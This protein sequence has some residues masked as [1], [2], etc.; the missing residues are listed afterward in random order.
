[1]FSFRKWFIEKGLC[2]LVKTPRRKP[3]N[4]KVRLESLEERVNPSPIVS[5]DLLD[6]APGSTALITANNFKVGSEVVFQV[7][8]M[9]NAGPDGVWG[10]PDDVL[11]TVKN[12]GPDHQ[13]WAVT[14]GV[15]WMV[16]AGADNVA[17]TADD[18]IA[19]DLDKCE[20][21]SIL[22]SWFVNP[23]DSI[24]AT[25]GLSATGLNPDGVVETAMAIFTDAIKTDL[26][27][28]EN[29]VSSGVS[30]ANGGIN[31]GQGLYLEGDYIPH[32]VSFSGLTVG[33][34]YMFNISFN[35]FQASSNSG[36]FV[37]IGTY[38]QSVI[39]TLVFPVGSGTPVNDP[40]SMPDS[41]GTFYISNGGSVSGID[42]D[43]TNVTKSLAISTTE[44]QATVTFKALDTSA[45]FYY[46]LKLA[47]P[48]EVIVPAGV[49]PNTNPTNGADG[50]TGLSLQSSVVNGP[51]GPAIGGGGN[52]QVAPGAVVQGSI[53]GVKWSDLNGNGIKESNEP[54][55]AGWTIQIYKDTDGDKIFGAGDTLIASTI[56]ADGSSDANKDGKIDA[57]D[58]GYY[59]FAVIRGTYFVRE[60]QQLGWTPTFPINN[61][62]GLL[63]IDETTPLYAN[64]NFG[65]MRDKPT[66]DI[67]KE[68]TGIVNEGAINQVLVYTFTVTNTSPVTTGSETINSL[69][70]TILGDL[71]PAFKAA[72]GGSAIIAA[73]ATVTFTVNYTAPAA[74]AGVSIAN[75][76][77]VVG[78][79]DQ[80]NPVTD[81][82]SDIEFYKDLQPAITIVKTPDPTSVNEGG[83]GNQVVTY[84]YLLT[85]TSPAGLFDPLSAITVSDTDGV[86]VYVG[87][88]DGDNL[89][90]K[91]ETWVYILTV[92]MPIQDAFT[93]H[94]NTV[95]ATGKDDE[96]NI[97][98]GMDTAEVAYTD[99]I[100]S[101]IKVAKSHTGT[102]D[103]GASGQT[104]VYTYTVYDDEL[105]P[106]DPTKVTSLEDN[107]I[108]NI[109]P[110]FIAANGGSDILQPGGSVTFTV[111]Y[112]APVANANVNITNIVVVVG[113]DNEG[114][115]TT[116][117]ATDTAV[118]L[119]LQPAIDITKTHTGT[120]DEGTSGQ[121]L[122][123][124]FEVTNNSVATT[125]PI[126]ITTLSDTVLGDLMSAFMAANGGSAVLQPSTSVIFKV[127]YTAPVANAGVVIAN[128]VTVIGQDDEQNPVEDSASDR[129]TY[130]DVKPMIDIQKSHT[131]TINEG[132]SGQVLVYS[133]TVSNMS[134][135]S[136]DPVTVSSLSDSVLGDLMPAF[137]AANGGSAVIPFSGSVTFSVSYTAPVANAGVVIA[138]TVTVIGQDDE[139]NPVED[140]ASDSEVYKNLNPA[141]TVTKTPDK[142]EVPIGA[143]V[144]YTYY[145]TNSSM[146]GV[147][148]PLSGITLFDTDGTPSYV[149]GDSNM[150][151]ILEVGE[152][153]KYVLTYTTTSFGIHNNTVTASG[154][155]DEN[156]TAVGY[157]S[158]AINVS[159]QQENGKTLGYYSNKNGQKD[160]T[161]SPN[162]TTLLSSI[163]NNLFAPVTG[164]LAKDSVNS[165]LVDANGN[166]KPLSFFSSYANVRNYLLGATASNMG[167]M[168]SAQLLTTEFNVQLG[169]IFASKSIIAS[170][171]AMPIASQNSMSVNNGALN[172][173]QV[174]Y[175]GVANIQTILNA[176]IASLKASPNTLTSGPD[177]VYQEGLKCLLDAMNNNQSIFLP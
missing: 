35:Y 151:S 122:V 176:A 53:S 66:I 166:Y 98:T 12:S 101:S 130:D 164:L 113:Q 37:D 67:T 90:E 72:N 147:F 99:V 128:T 52:V 144:T 109:L 96:N 143:I 14:D 132:T 24:G 167:Y 131:G 58:L 121:I 48:G 149:S 38:N 172:W 45:T 154:K 87:G 10:T 59:N 20:N 51:T 81:S 123:Y 43:V 9:I 26:R 21:G 135:A 74:N 11:D 114:N 44:K 142:T 54:G 157:A 3:V 69:N 174:S 115:I 8:H 5:T 13:P 84:T 32:A 162:G 88:D 71:L 153:W 95:T 102:I 42:A 119:D 127:N 163:Y 36:G 50:F 83:I 77:T 27:G 139:Q 171:V 79:D 134:T 118:Y 56:T 2:K 156:I 29:I 140:S 15:W 46:G 89:L 110:Y 111:N 177:R 49:T 158:A 173:M 55:L 104:L 18:V 125:D 133:F 60:V 103:E 152:T 117:S 76:V 57:N 93:V 34:V 31:A 161:G 73:G 170:A 155:D 165:V 28:W 145:V 159:A 47:V 78:K 70:D 136:T 6:Y 150:N 137:M 112:T 148:D 169:R 160:L 33:S 40:T 41:G 7:S 129:V 91:G 68:H 23:D 124:S 80:E 39:P 120:I 17:G 19:G 75:I 85:N 86:P 92:T 175:S 25:F 65:N 146:A 100:P 126:T 64:Q 108:G 105:I 22:T 4:S 16:N 141:I 82:A 168:L 62:H 138:N 61:I 107:I 97:A 116:A 1:M 94:T 30:W 106:T 63:N